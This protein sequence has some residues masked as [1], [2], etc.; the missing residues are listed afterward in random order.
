MVQGAGHYECEAALT[1]H[2][3]FDYIKQIGP[4]IWA[5]VIYISGLGINVGKRLHY[6]V[7]VWLLMSKV[8][9]DL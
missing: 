5:I 7:S 6:G 1:K 3:F 2:A 9:K 8:S 4:S